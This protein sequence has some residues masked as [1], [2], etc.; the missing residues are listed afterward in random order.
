M[1]TAPLPIEVSCA[2]FPPYPFEKFRTR[3]FRL[4]GF[5]AR[6]CLR[7][8]RFNF[9]AFRSAEFCPLYLYVGESG[10]ASDEIYGM[11]VGWLGEGEGEGEGVSEDELF[12]A[13][14]IV[15]EE[16]DSATNV[17]CFVTSHNSQYLHNIK[18]YLISNSLYRFLRA[19]CR[20]N[21]LWIS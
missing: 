16:L 8:R 14:E 19:L 7:P 18:L 20:R 13:M 17:L 12:E 2:P 3:H 1:P 5:I 10:S 9:S 15:R 4:G 6:S 11:S 21:D